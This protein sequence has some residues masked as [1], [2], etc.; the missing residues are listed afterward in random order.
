MDVNS[1]RLA[2]WYGWLERSTFG[3][4][5]WQARI[6]HL[7]SLSGRVLVLGDGDGRFAAALA[8]RGVRVEVLELSAGMI[9]QA[10]TQPG[11]S[12][13]VF[14]HADAR[15]HDFP[16]AT[17]NA[18]VAHFFFDC[19]HPAELAALVPRLTQA[20]KPGGICI[21]SEFRAQRWWQRAIVYSMYLAFGW[22]TG[23]T[24][25]QLP[26]YEAA[27]AAAGLQKQAER[28]WL[29]ALVVAQQWRANL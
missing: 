6:E 29:G 28:R 13:V 12:A 20:L 8:R 3:P 10:R 9:A 22:L 24:V 26:N 17:Y 19:F 23:L 21:L 5:L 16:A 15:C 14:H 7:S 25:R 27:F 18:V 1:D 4:I 11:S 2:P